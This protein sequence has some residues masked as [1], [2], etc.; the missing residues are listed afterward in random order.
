MSIFLLP[1]FTLLPQWPTHE[2]NDW[3]IWRD[4]HIAGRLGQGTWP[5]VAGS[6]AA[7]LRRVGTLPAA[8][9][10]LGAKAQEFTVN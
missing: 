1:D 8:A 9:I 3:S 7:L 6:A 10:L 2:Q 4:V 5:A